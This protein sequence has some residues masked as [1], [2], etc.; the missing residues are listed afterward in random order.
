MTLLKVPHNKIHQAQKF[1]QE[2]CDNWGRSKS[3]PMKLLLL[4]WKKDTQCFKALVPKRTIPVSCLQGFY[5]SISGEFVSW[6][7]LYRQDIQPPVNWLQR[8][9]IRDAEQRCSALIGRKSSGQVGQVRHLQV[10]LPKIFQSPVKA[11]QCSFRAIVKN[12][13]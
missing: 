7:F 12:T 4:S 1:T 5:F 6:T 8:L 9:W 10:V 3:R 2:L 13:E 11:A